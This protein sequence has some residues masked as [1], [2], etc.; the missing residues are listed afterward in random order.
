[1]NQTCVMPGDDPID[2]ATSNP[3][4]GTTPDAPDAA[5]VCFGAGF[6]SICPSV[7]P[8]TPVVVNSATT[9]DTDTSPLCIAYTGTANL[10]V[11]AGT[12]VAI[13][14]SV[15]AT[16]KTPLVIL[17]TSTLTI[18][19]GGLLDVA[20]RR[21]NTAGAGA[22][23]SECGV[24]GVAGAGEGGC[25][26]SFGGRGGAGAI[27]E[28]AGNG[29][30]AAP[31]VAVSTFHGGCPGSEGNPNSAGGHGGGAVYLIAV[32]SITIAGAIN[33]SG[34]G[35]LHPIANNDGGG[36]GGSGGMIGLDAPTIMVTG[37]VFANGGGAGSGNDGGQD[38][39]E[40]TSPFDVA[41]GGVDGNGGNGGDGAA[42]LILDGGDG[43]P[44]NDGGGGGGGGA[45]VIRVF[46]P[47]VLGGRISPP[48]T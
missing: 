23:S 48:S 24:G 14:A 2:A 13:T 39:L 40:S 9:I 45:G 43:L 20:S 28:G 29:P 4:T 11:V 25:G 38:G 32:E 15:V 42:N 31:T 22:N 36:G 16:G 46:P 34:A 47:R 44:G 26:G 37:D 7:P 27:G 3:E 35:G 10:C 6:V 21:G 18:G 8:T 19:P 5:L 17:A 41:R 33:A 30:L 12:D 1:M